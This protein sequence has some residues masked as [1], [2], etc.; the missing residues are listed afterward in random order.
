VISL[1]KHIDEGPDL[2]RSVANAYLSSLT[3]VCRAASRTA[4]QL[5]PS[6]QGN[7]D[8]LA[9]KLC[10]KTV[11]EI[12]RKVVNEIDAWGER[13]SGYFKQKATEVREILLLVSQTAQAAGDKDER[14]VSQLS[15]FSGR[16]RDIA[17]LED[18]S[19]I[20]QSLAQSATDLKTCVDRMAEDGKAMVSNLQ[21]EV[22]AYQVRLQEAEMQAAIDTLTGLDNRRGI[23]R[24]MAERVA[25]G[26]PFSLI[27]IDLN[28]FKEINDSHGH[29]AGDELLKQFAAE[30][31]S[32]FRQTDALG[33]WGGDEFL[34][35]FD[36]GGEEAVAAVNKAS[37]WLFGQYRLKSGKVHVTASIGIA[38]WNGSEN[39]LETLNRADADMYTQKRRA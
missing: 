33:R 39:V 9:G 24:R 15:A 32:R 34:V 8:A 30:L 20:R 22:M 26:R 29:L 37:E 11:A 38:E 5:T 18:L 31:R 12:D 27:L 7:L 21:S 1:K 28:C 35:I 4:P 19:R 14:Y 3:A 25:K 2:V 23:E 16:L 17:S 36:G 13:T 10:L 6:L